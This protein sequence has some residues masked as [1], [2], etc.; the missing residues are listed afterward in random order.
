M[1]IDELEHEV[2]VNLELPLSLNTQN[3]LKEDDTISTM[4]KRYGYPDRFKELITA[5]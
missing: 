1:L 2:K 5:G 4:A 3:C